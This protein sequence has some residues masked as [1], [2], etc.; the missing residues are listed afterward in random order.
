MRLLAD[1]LEFRMM[2][3]VEAVHTEAVCQDAEDKGDDAPLL[4]EPETEGKTSEGQTVMIQ[5]VRQQY[6]TAEGDHRPDQ[7]KYRH[8][9]EVAAPVAPQRRPH[10][11]VMQV[12]WKRGA[13]GI[14]C[15]GWKSTL[16]FLTITQGISADLTQAGE[17]KPP[18]MAGLFSRTDVILVWVY[19]TVTFVALGA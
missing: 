8:E 7:Q 1:G 5:P 6:A 13:G 2:A 4:C 3:A 16:F 11:L 19:R 18:P 14:A 15:H 17:K 10:A 12:R 9:P